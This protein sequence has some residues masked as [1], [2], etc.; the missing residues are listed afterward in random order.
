[1]GM[2][3]GLLYGQQCCACECEVCKRSMADSL[4]KVY[5]RCVSRVVC[6]CLYRYLLVNM[7]SEEDESSPEVYCE[8]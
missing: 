4:S 6:S 3:V 1:M 2:L 5:A 8:F 7:V